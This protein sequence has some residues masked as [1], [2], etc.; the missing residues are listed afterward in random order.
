ML[1]CK[2]GRI[3]KV[4]FVAVERNFRPARV[5]TRAGTRVCPVNNFDP[6]LD[7]GGAMNI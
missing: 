2:K 3:G 6:D 7:P 4:E 5:H 1:T